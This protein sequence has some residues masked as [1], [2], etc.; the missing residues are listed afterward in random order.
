MNNEVIRFLAKH[1][2]AGCDFD[3][4]AAELKVRREQEIFRFQGVFLQSVFF[5][6]RW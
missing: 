4:M 2:L 1:I 3:V 5:K 6:A